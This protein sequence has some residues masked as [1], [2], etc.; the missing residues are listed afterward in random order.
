MWL[1]VLGQADDDEDVLDQDTADDT[2]AYHIKLSKWYQGAF[3][4]VQH[5][6]FWFLLYIC[7]TMRAPLRHFFLFVQKHAEN[8]NAGQVMLA[9]VTGKL[10]E[11]EEEYRVLQR[12]LTAIVAKAAELSGCQELFQHDDAAM[13]AIDLLA[14]KICFQQWASFQR[15]I[16]FPLKQHLGERNLR[17][18]EGARHCDTC[19]RV[20]SSRVVCN[21]STSSAAVP[22]FNVLR[23]PFKLL[24]L[25]K[26]RPLRNCVRRQGL[27]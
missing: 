23:Y 22:G 13:S 14:R 24:W 5:P 6:L 4:A 8:C 3:N 25:L 11:I 16:L 12:N 2:K 20:E 1:P 19:C 21:T 7:R 9:L 15:R 17:C 18:S 27:D 26:E 10:D